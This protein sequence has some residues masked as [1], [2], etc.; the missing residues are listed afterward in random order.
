[1]GQLDR[2]EAVGVNGP[3]PLRAGEITSLD[4]Q[5]LEDDG[6]TSA[7]EVESELPPLPEALEEVFES[8]FLPEAFEDED[9]PPDAVALDLERP[10]FVSLDEAEGIGEADKSTDDAVE[11]AG[12]LE[13]GEFAQRSDDDLLDPSAFAAGLDDLEVLMGG[14][15]VADRFG[16]DEHDIT[17]IPCIGAMS[18]E[19]PG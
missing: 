10:G 4:E 11:R 16:A 7:L 2:V 15:A 19:N 1:V 17:S 12:L 3:D 18:R 13:V 14:A 9:G 5:S 6:K 8:E